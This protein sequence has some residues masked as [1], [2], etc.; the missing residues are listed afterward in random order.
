[1]Y[2]VILGDGCLTNEQSYGYISLHKENKKHILEKAEKYFQSKFVRS[3]VETK[4]N[5]SRLYLNKNVN[6]PFKYSDVYANKEKICNSRYLNLPLNKSKMILKGLL[7]TDGS[8]GNELVFDNT[9]YNLIEAVKFICLK[10]GI[11]GGY[12]RD[13]VGESKNKLRYNI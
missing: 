8:K 11:L 3:R 13:R 6:L 12:I 10:I 2:G 4:D 7:D 9:S 1:M 5:T